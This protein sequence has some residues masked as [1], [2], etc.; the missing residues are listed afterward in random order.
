MTQSIQEDVCKLYAIL[1]QELY[2]MDFGTF[3]IMELIIP[4]KHWGLLCT[5]MW[6][7]TP[8]NTY[9]VCHKKR[10]LIWL[11]TLMCVTL[12]LLPVHKL[13]VNSTRAAYISMECQFFCYLACEICVCLQPFKK[14][15]SF[16]QGSSDHWVRSIWS[17]CHQSKFSCTSTRSLRIS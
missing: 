1:Q 14:M 10:Q 3:R 2:T 12:P 11:W 16:P 4:H 13:Q 8:I 5:H 15:S 6:V 9:I 17:Y 7:S